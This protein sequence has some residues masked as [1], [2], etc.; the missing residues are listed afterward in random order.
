MYLDLTDG[1]YDHLLPIKEILSAVIS[2]VDK[3]FMIIG[4]FPRDA[5][6]RRTDSSVIP[7]KDIDIIVSNLDFF[8]QSFQDLKNSLRLLN[9]KFQ[10][11]G[12]TADLLDSIPA[13]AF[14]HNK[15][16]IPFLSQKQM[17]DNGLIEGHLY[18]VNEDCI[19]AL[20]ERKIILSDRFKQKCD[21]ELPRL[22]IPSIDFVFTLKNIPRYLIKYSKQYKLSQETRAY[23]Y[24]IVD[25]LLN[26]EPQSHEY[27]IYLESM[28]F[29]MFMGGG[30]KPS[31]YENSENAIILRAINKFREDYDSLKNA[32]LIA[33]EE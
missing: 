17:E 28:F 19:K 20:K 22:N 29:D 4:G 10:L 15:F 16:F 31:D 25:R 3:P 21:E 13:D 7:S 5:Y 27:E 26:I 18:T 2:T 30:I 6:D 11:R 24:T 33:Y 1:Q 12:R 14:L 8:G 23:F 9:N 32:D